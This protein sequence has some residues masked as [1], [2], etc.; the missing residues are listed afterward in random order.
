MTIMTTMSCHEVK[1]LLDACC[2]RVG[3]GHH[4]MELNSVQYFDI[5]L[6]GIKGYI[7]GWKLMGY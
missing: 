6:I 1:K 5:N 4:T 3:N 7:V 2:K